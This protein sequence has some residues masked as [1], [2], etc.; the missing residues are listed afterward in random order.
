MAL[1]RKRLPV[2]VSLGA[3]PP[4]LFPAEGT[5][6]KRFGSRFCVK[7]PAVNVFAFRFWFPKAVFRGPPP[8][9][10]PPDLSPEREEVGLGMRVLLI[11][12]TTT[13]LAPLLNRFES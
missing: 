2:H 10:V 8:G 13:N 4:E 9:G 11:V 1:K 12:G 7:L 5:R 3:I 6:A